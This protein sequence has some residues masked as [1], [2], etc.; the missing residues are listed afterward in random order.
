MMHQDPLKNPYRSALALSLGTGLILLLPGVLGTVGIL[1]QAVGITTASSRQGE[2]SLLGGAA[3]MVILILASLPGVLG[4]YKRKESAG[5]RLMTLHGGVL[6]LAFLA[7]PFSLTMPSV[8]P[9]ILFLL[10]SAGIWIIMV[11]RHP[12]PGKGTEA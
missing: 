2:F 7:F 4:F 9:L 12:G 3:V 8:M 11:L 6:T 10:G 5:R 1:L